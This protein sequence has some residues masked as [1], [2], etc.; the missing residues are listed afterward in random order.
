MT[1]TIAFINKYTVY[2]HI[3]PNG[4]RY[5][6]ITRLNPVKRWKNGAGYKKNCHFT[7]AIQKYGWDNIMHVILYCGLS[8][9]M[10]EAKEIE[11]IADHKSN[12]REY[13]YNID[14][15][16]NAHGMHSK[17]ARKKMSD[18]HKGKKNALYGKNHT[19]ES[20]KKISKNRRGQTDGSKHWHYGQTWSE[21]VRKKMSKSHCKK[22]KCV[23][24]GTIYDSV[25]KAGEETATNCHDISKCC[26]GV[27][28]YKTAGGYHWVYAKEVA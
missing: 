6:G 26:R 24:T 16:G 27:K 23:E 8:K 3:C 1:N 7:S 9:E 20:R 25:K 4:K 22:V 18:S 14:N 10:A 17:E 11:L 28:Y 15:G 12:N 19:E 2:M 13:G 5:I 21:D